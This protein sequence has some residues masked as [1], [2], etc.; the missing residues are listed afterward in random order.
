MEK[1]YKKNQSMHATVQNTRRLVIP[2]INS[3]L[4]VLP[5]YLLTPMLQHHSVTGEVELC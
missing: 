3:C 1:L 2:C 4:V 5:A